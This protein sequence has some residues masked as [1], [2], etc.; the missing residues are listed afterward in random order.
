MLEK[1]GKRNKNEKNEWG[2]EKWHL[3]DSK[4]MQF[5]HHIMITTLLHKKI[6]RI[7]KW[8]ANGQK[9]CLL[10]WAESHFFSSN[11]KCFFAHF[12]AN[13]W[14]LC[15]CVRFAHYQ[16]HLFAQQAEITTNICVDEM[17]VIARLW[18]HFRWL[19]QMDSRVNAKRA[20][21]NTIECVDK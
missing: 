18:I 11:R 13:W 15:Y 21:A 17:L 8:N 7:N 20:N 5:V 6:A 1:N 12:S 16:I 9:V 4:C 2:T 3:F 14:M 10:T 19:K